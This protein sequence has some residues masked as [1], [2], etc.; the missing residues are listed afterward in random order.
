MNEITVD[1]WTEIPKNYTG[2][3]KYTNGDQEWLKNDKWHREDGPAEIWANGD[4]SWYLDDKRY[5]REA[6]YRELHK[7]GI[8]TEQEL[9][10]ELL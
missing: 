7:R 1:N 9:F 2:H 6:Y 8:I 5:S 3:V 4:Q 10:I